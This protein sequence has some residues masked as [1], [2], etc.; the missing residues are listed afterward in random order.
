MLIICRAFITLPLMR[1]FAMPPLPWSLLPMVTTCADAAVIINER[2]T[3][4][5]A[6]AAECRR[7]TLMSAEAIMHDSLIT[8]FVMLLM[9]YAAITR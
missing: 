3:P 6:Y 5:H 1:Y 7:H 2:F 4:L 9:R 8:S